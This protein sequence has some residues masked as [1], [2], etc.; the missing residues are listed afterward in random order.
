MKKIIL[1]V[2]IVLAV[3]PSITYS[4]SEFK[5][6]P[7]CAEILEPTKNAPENARGVALIYNIE[8]EFNDK[9]T[10]LS[11]HAL[12]LP[13]PSSFGNYNDYEVL[14]YIPEKISWRFSLIQYDDTSWGGK[15]DEIS[16]LMR[17]TQ[18]KVRPISTTTNNT[19]PVV[20]EK[21]VSCL[22]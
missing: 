12:H 6:L 13:K 21:T 20:L 8:R 18:I 15:S 11:V 5:K 2:I 1:S 9:R 19:G 4:E 3:L 10:S 17:P 7:P 22:N 16:P 14:A